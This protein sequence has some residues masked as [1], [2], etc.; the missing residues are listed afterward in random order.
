MKQWRTQNFLIYSDLVSFALGRTIFF[1]G[2]LYKQKLILCVICIYMAG[3]E[4]QEVPARHAHIQINKIRLVID[5][6]FGCGAV[7]HVVG[8][9][10]YRGLSDT[11]A[12]TRVV[13]KFQCSLMPNM[14]N[15]SLHGT[16]NLVTFNIL[17]VLHRV[18][19]CHATKFDG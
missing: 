3:L 13:H 4:V 10:P 6:P 9:P 5:I 11:D 19:V 2:F 1:F 15:L 12:G 7:F 8:Q 17:N 16:D 14:N 18:C